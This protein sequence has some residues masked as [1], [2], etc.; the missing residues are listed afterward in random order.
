MTAPCKPTRKEVAAAKGR[1]IPDLI[2]PHLKVL[3]CG[4]N[5]GLYS[6]AVGHHFAR[7]GNRFWPVLHA[8]GFTPRILSPF[9]E[10]DLLALG[11]GLT[12]IVERSTAGAE[13]LKRE[14]L[15][16]SRK[17][18]VEKVRKYNPRFIAFLGIGAYRI[19]F[20]RPKA[21]IGRQDVRLYDTGVW[22]LPS[23]SGLNAFYR[24]EDLVQ[25]FTELRIEAERKTRR[26]EP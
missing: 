1:A 21:V 15:I 20:S 3:F 18:L 2:A 22:I 5:P 13:E 16:E 11:Y 7:P 23:P 26:T 17:T 10:E 6:G 8:S 19:A 12:N 4:I 9:E 24:F 14:E 25:L